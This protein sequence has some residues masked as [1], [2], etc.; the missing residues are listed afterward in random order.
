MVGAVGPLAGDQRCC[1]PGA[2]EYTWG[3]VRR[4]DRSEAEWQAL[5]APDLFAIA[6]KAG[7]EAPFSGRYYTCK[8]PGVYRCACCDAAL[9]D[10]AAKYDSG[11]GWPSYTAPVEVEAVE[12]HRD[13]SHGMLR[14]EVRCAG[15]GAHLGHV[16]DDGPAPAG[17]RYCINSVCLRLEPPVGDADP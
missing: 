17:L 1:A 13:S 3:M 5:L 9:F 2:A 12:E 11:S 14:V 7:T 6:R 16:F 4:I 15:C 10:A 8:D